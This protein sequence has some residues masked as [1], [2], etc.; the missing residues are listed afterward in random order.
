M[1]SYQ[2]SFSLIDLPRMVLGSNVP[3]D[4]RDEIPTR[5]RAPPGQQQEMRTLD[6]SVP[7]QS[8]PSSRM[9]QLAQGGVMNSKDEFW[10]EL[11]QIS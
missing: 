5:D 1:E 4:L 6:L 8:K 2:L 3:A 10:Q 7:G 9:D 11:K